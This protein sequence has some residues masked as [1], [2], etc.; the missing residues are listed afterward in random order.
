MK[1][2]KLYTFIGII[3]LF[4]ICLV[5]AIK[6]FH[7]PE[8]L[9]LLRAVMATNHIKN[10]SIKH[11][12][13]EGR[14]GSI[15]EQWNLPYGY[16][17]EGEVDGLF[18]EVVRTQDALYSRTSTDGQDWSDW[19]GVATP[20]DERPFAF[21]TEFRYVSRLPN[22]KIDSVSYIVLSLDMPRGSVNFSYHD[23]HYQIWLDPKTLL[24]I[25]AKAWGF[26]NGEAVKNL[27]FSYSVQP[28]TI[29][30]PK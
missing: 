3:T 24:P 26:W 27:Y 19:E 8:T 2:K 13:I 18:S 1:Q 22:E 4:L 7:I 29:T 11:E 15:Y 30:P 14:T 25:K 5:A 6:V 21:L 17:A 28:I 16:T 12:F 9:I 23:N 20:F 10:V